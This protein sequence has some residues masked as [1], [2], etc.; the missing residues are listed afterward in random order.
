M[1]DPRR[2][3]DAVLTRYLS[4]ECTPDEVLAVERWVREDPAN[5]GEL[6]RL[7]A[8][9]A[10]P[11]EAAESGPEADVDAVWQRVRARIELPAP[12]DVRVVQPARGARSVPTFGLGARPRWATAIKVAASIA[13][14]AGAALAG[15]ALV[16]TPQKPAAASPTYSVISTTRGQRL[17]VRLADG[18][19]VALAPGTTLRTPSTYGVHDRT[20]RLEGEAAFTVTHDAARPF[21]VETRLAVARDLGTHFVVRAYAGDPLTDVVVAEGRVAVGHGSS[22]AGSLSADSLVITRGDRVRIDRA[23]RLALARD[24]LLDRYFGWTEGRLVFHRTPLGEAITQLERWYDLDIRLAS[25]AVGDQGVTASF[26][27]GEPASQVLQVIATVLNLQV[28]QT[29]A[30]TY[31]LRAKP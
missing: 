3:P 9:W 17:S 28:E 12:P 24:V 16:R 29:G 2:P 18:T 26:G 15:R 11:R 31:T 13:L 20:V 6:E 14:V 23:G 27:E 1:I 30:R 25:P 7:K 21:A 5:E 10:R 22:A 8:A 19:L 4:G